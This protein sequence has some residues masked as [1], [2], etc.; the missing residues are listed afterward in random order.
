M[1]TPKLRTKWWR[2]PGSSA[3][4]SEGVVGAVR[5]HARGHYLRLD[6]VECTFCWEWMSVTSLTRRY[7]QTMPKESK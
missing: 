7:T 3:L 1:R 2:K 6:S 4:V 5:A